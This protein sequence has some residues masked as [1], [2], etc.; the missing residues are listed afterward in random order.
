MLFGYVR[1]S[2]L[3]QARDDRTSL[4]EQERVIRGLA[5]SMGIGQYDLQI[6]SDAGVSAA[7]PLVERPAGRDM[8]RA[9]KPGDVIVA[10]KLDRMF[11]DALDAQRTYKRLKMDGIDLILYDMGLDPVTKDGMS[12]FFFTML[13]AFADLERCRI[14]ERMADGRRAKRERGGHIGGQA[15][16]GFEKIGEGRAAIVKPV[17]AEQEVIKFVASLPSKMRLVDIK[18]A[19]DNS[20]HKPRSG[21]D[22]WQFMTVKRIAAR[23]EQVP[24][25]L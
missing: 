22:E 23:V 16:Y 9:A 21:K 7:I 4:Q 10:S 11:R 15:P 2:T 18:K 25:C 19:L 8:L 24:Q 14:A 13:S 5:M 6:Y 17:P 1:V 3:E 12:K 20:G